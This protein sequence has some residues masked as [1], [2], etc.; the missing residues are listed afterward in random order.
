MLARDA[1][2]DKGAVVSR[3]R[4]TLLL[5]L[6]GRHLPLI[7]PLPVP[8]SPPSHTCRSL[9]THRDTEQKPRHL[10]KELVRAP[11]ITPRTHAN[12]HLPAAPARPE[13]LP[14][15]GE[16][17][18]IQTP[19]L[20]ISGP[21]AGSPLQKGTSP[22]RLT[23]GSTRLRAFKPRMSFS[24]LEIRFGS[25]SLAEDG[26]DGGSDR[27]SLLRVKWRARRTPPPVWIY[28]AFK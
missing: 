26:D 20:P 27:P 22:P 25:S 18:G 15:K 16:K 5:Q 23:S 10:I 21:G 17:Q 13:P 24:S 3:S 2:G 1:A 12:I 8:W 9:I 14:D 6:R 11:E 19:T 4:R 28:L 7:Y